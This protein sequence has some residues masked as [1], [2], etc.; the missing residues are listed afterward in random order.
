MALIAPFRHY[1]VY[2]ALMRRIGRAWKARAEKRAAGD[3]MIAAE[4]GAP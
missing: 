4:R 3:A 1:I 2:P